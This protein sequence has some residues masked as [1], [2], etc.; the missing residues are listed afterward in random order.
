VDCRLIVRAVIDN[1]TE[2]DPDDSFHRY[3][4]VSIRVLETIKGKHSDRLEF[5]HDGDFG[6]FRLVDLRKNKQE[7]LIFLEHWNRSRRFNRSQGAYAYTRFP[8]VVKSVAVLTP[9]NVQLAGSRLPIRS[10]DLTPL[11]TP[12]QLIDTVKNYL[13]N[14]RGQEPV[15]G[16]TFGL[17][18]R[19]RDVQG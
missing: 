15:Y 8:H 3:Q 17:P 19:L 4:T 16:V 18:A 10:S 7:L 1:V 2:L 5:V 6:W 13:K 11:S 12:E 9:G 14:H